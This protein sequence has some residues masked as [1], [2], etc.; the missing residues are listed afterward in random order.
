MKSI[1]L[2][3]GVETIVSVDVYHEG[4]SRLADVTIELNGISKLFEVECTGGD[5]CYGYCFTADDLI[6][7]LEKPIIL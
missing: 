1:I 6:G 7:F 5:T 4:A 3:D 2:I